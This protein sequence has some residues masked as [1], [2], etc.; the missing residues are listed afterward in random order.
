MP[1]IEIKHKKE[2]LAFDRM[3]SLMEQ[4][5]T[6]C[7]WDNAQTNDSL[8]T[9]TIEELYELSQAIL[10]RNDEDIKKEL[11]DVMMHV[12]FYALIGKEKGK[13][14]ITDVLDSLSEK[15]IRRHPHVFNKD[16]NLTAQ[17]VEKNWERI[18]LKEGNRSTFAGVPQTLPSLI[19]AYRLQD[20][21]K[22]IGFDW[23]SKEDVWKK[24]E[25]EI[26]EL[27]E[28][29]NKAGGAKNTELEF[30]DVLFSLINY[31][32]FIDVNPDTALEMTNRKFKRRFEYMETKAKEN[33]KPL[34]DMNTDEMEEL[35]QEAKQKEKVL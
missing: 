4:V 11:G 27:K 25:E 10:D 6:E 33:G 17:D 22:G 15:L 7:P 35:W 30:G 26:G 13:F 3:L 24:V 5:R 1:D 9:L 8:R 20:K 31:A 23:K 34:Q 29:E 19:K 18:K 2:V 28:E 14:D 16:L 21:A 12:V 32:R